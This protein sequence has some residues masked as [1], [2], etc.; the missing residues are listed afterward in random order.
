MHLQD[1][2]DKDLD[3]NNELESA[4]KTNEGSTEDQTERDEKDTLTLEEKLKEVFDEI[5][6][7]GS[8]FL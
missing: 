2:L 5:D 8:G 6:V 3:K 4:A 1:L 7:D